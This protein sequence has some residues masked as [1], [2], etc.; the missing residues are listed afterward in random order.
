[1]EN[2]DDVRK[3]KVEMQIRKKIEQNNPRHEDIWNLFLFQ[4]KKGAPK[5][6]NEN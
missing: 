3:E 5:K 2:I 1:M 6:W 4:K